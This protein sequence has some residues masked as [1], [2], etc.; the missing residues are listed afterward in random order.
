[1]RAA[2]GVTRLA[3]RKL[4]TTGAPL[5][6]VTFELTPPAPSPRASTSAPF[7][8][9]RAAAVFELALV[10]SV[11]PLLL[12]D[13]TGLDQATPTPVAYTVRLKGSPLRSGWQRRPARTPIHDTPQRLHLASS[14]PPIRHREHG[15][16]LRVHRGGA[17]RAAAASRVG[18]DGRQTTPPPQLRCA[19][20]AG[21]VAPPV[22]VPASIATASTARR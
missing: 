15:G 3:T 2:R 22:R 7:L 11:H 10:G 18:P 21:D 14:R 9:S 20:Q 12:G 17:A 4:A 6:V 19:S 13:P 8:G 16:C 1:M 5:G